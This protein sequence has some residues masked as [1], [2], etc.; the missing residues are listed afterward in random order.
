MAKLYTQFIKEITDLSIDI[1]SI[2]DLENIEQYFLVNYKPLYRQY[3]SFEKFNNEHGS[4][5]G[6]IYFTNNNK[7][8]FGL[9]ESDDGKEYSITSITAWN[10]SSNPTFFIN[11]HN[12]KC[13]VWLPLLIKLFHE[14]KIGTYKVSE[15]G[16]IVKEASE[17]SDSKIINI[18]VVPVEN[19]VAINPDVKENEKIAANEAISYDT[20]LKHLASL[21]KLVGKK[22]LPGLIVTGR[23]GASKSHTIEETLKSI[24]LQ[25]DV[26][27]FIVKGTTTN[28]GLY[29]KC[30]D[31]RKKIIIFD[32]CDKVFR[33]DDS[34]NLLKALLDS[35]KERRVSSNS[36]NRFKLADVDVKQAWTLIQQGKYPNEYNFEGSIFMV[37]NLPIDSIDPDGA[38][39]SRS[40]LIDVNPSD[41]EMLE[42]MEKVI[43]PNIYTEVPM[44]DK[45]EV[46]NLIKNNNKISIRT[47]TKA[48]GI[49]QSG[50]P[51]WK[52]LVIRYA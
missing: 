49:Q 31:Y 48:I 14:P 28:A 41:M 5:F 29:E 36:T 38:L 10:K 6:V 39:K 32:D 24:G 1:K 30:F 8:R 23:T 35:K 43:I 19:D 40:L 18:N 52:E 3:G 7:I 51:D 9:V 47:L 11:V 34:R 20:L 4:G 22:V 16:N 15:S 26:D 12:I 37:S 25:M 42:R 50:D 46:F 21:T 44:K 45:L 17:S 2:Q 27:W 13:D 33:D